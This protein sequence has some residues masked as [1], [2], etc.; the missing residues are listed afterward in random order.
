MGAGRGEQRGH[1]QRRKLCVCA[2][3]HGL[4]LTPPLP[5]PFNPQSPPSATSRAGRGT[6]VECG[7]VWC[8]M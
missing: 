5:A 6:C 1:L 3:H 2:H 4:I 8:S 7:V